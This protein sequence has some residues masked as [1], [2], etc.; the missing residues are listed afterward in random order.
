VVNK[1]EYILAV[2]LFEDIQS[3]R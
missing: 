2:S 1:D 3:A